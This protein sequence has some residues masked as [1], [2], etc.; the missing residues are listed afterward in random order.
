MSRPT[1]Y[2]SKEFWT[3]PPPPEPP[4][5]YQRLTG[6]WCVLAGHRIEPCF[7]GDKPT[8]KCARC[9]AER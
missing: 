7:T 2:P 5:F 3:D 6:L 8:I 1:L 4:G 9:G